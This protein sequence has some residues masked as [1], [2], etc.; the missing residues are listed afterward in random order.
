LRT[1][2]TNFEAARTIVPSLGELRED[3]RAEQA[4]EAQQRAELAAADQEATPEAE[5][6]TGRVESVRPEASPQVRNFAVDNSVTAAVSLTERPEG[7]EGAE[8]HAPQAFTPSRI[9]VLV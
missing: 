9:D 7:A 8:S 1:L 4:V 6:P 2:D 3:S 5:V